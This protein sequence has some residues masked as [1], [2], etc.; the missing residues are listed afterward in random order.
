M[1]RDHF[2]RN[3][4]ESWRELEALV[5]QA[6]RR[7]S[8]LGGDGVLRL[9]ELYRSAA[10]DLAFARRRWPG[11][12]TVARLEDLVSRARHLVY[13]S[14][15]RGLSPVRFL[16]TGYWRLVA[17]RPVLLA[18]A[19]V[20]FLGPALLAGGWALDDPGAAGGLVPA[21][22]RSV[23]EPRTEDTDLGFSPSEE[24]GFAAEIFT[25]NIRV[26]FLAFAGGI[27]G[28]LVT[29][30]VLLFNGILLGTVA[31][32]AWGAGNG[33]P[34]V[35]LVTAHGVLEL[36]CIVVAGAAGLRLGWSIVEPGRLPRGMAVRQEA[37][38]AV[39][40]ALGTAPWLVLAGLVEGFLT[41]SGLG[42]ANAI[43][44]GVALGAVYWTLLVW[45]G[46]RPGSDFSRTS[47]LGVPPPP[48]QNRGQAEA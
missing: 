45:R 31:G 11:D 2:L 42:V 47:V 26:T 17:E 8:R 37:R 32:L 24:A 13:A 48:T 4:G 36:S 15:R 30:L 34:F 28:G 40:I 23:A 5:R 16:A 7:P 10:A 22:Y 35:E 19:T 41:P 6:G 46:S 38:R 3:R 29:A 1:T 21:E 20:L 39:L 25:N 33:G 14:P 44:I 9:G 18:V 27:T 43:A 12:P